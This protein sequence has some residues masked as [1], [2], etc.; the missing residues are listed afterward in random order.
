MIQIR[1]AVISA[2]LAFGF[3]SLTSIFQAPLAE[4]GI[5]EVT[6]TA[7]PENY[8]GHC[9]RKIKFTGR[10]EITSSPMSFNYHWE[11]SDGAKSPVKVVRVPKGNTRTVTVVDYWML[12]RKGH[13]EIWEKLV[14]NSGNTHIMSN[15][16]SAQLNCR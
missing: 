10:V 14:V 5:G 15:P 13:T 9:P 8:S 3:I 11:R 2:L 7:S 12:G 6:A 16:A 4:A 1:T